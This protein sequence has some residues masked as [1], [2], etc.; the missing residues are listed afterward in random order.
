MWQEMVAAGKDQAAS[1]FGD[2]RAAH[3]V[4]PGCAKKGR[5]LP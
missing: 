5:E 3:P 1:G 2:L 4:L